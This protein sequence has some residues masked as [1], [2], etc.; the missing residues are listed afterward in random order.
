MNDSRTKTNWLLCLAGGL[1]LGAVAG[2]AWAQCPASPPAPISV[3]TGTLHDTTP[4]G[5]NLIAQTFTAPGA[6]CVQLD[7]IKV[8]V[9]KAN[10]NPTVNLFLR[11]YQTTAGVPDLSNP[12][13]AAI[14]LGTT[15][16]A[17]YVDKIANFNPKPQ[18][19]GGTLYAFVLSAPGASGSTGYNAQAGQVPAVSPYSGGALYNSAV[20]TP[21]TFTPQ[22]N[23]DLLMEIVFSCCPVPEGGC[24]YS[25]GYWKN[26]SEAWPVASLSLGSNSYTQ[27]ELLSIL[28]QPTLGNGLVSLSHQLIAAKLNVA[29]GADDTD[30]S[31]SVAAA[32]TLIG[33]KVVPPVG[34]DFILP[35]STDAL[36]QALDDYNNGLTGPGHCPN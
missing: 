25:H 16:S 27:A 13:G 26:H 33:A 22:A 23:R 24:T 31:S 20:A 2:P 29:N 9:K 1:L 28:N 36:N 6:G 15:T 4:I 19:Q 32:D 35:S 12:I 3:T 18:L 11:L 7:S 30:V 34:S 10:Q 14:D 5:P 17:T 21:S 8:Q